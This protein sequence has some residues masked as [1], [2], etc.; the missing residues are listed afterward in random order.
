MRPKAGLGDVPA[1]HPTCS[2]DGSAR[3]LARI[4]AAGCRDPR[5]ETSERA[6]VLTDL[7][8]L[9]ERG[10]TAPRVVT[11]QVRGKLWEIKVSAQRVFYVIVAGPTMVLLHAYKKQGNKAPAHEIAVAEQRM[12]EVLAGAG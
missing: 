6:A 9:Q 11:R 12:R 7:K 5:L 8:D 3:E 1:M 2:V 10:L 4:I